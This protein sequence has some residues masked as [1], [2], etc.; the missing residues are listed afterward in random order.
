[1]R[2]RACAALPW[3]THPAAAG[4]RGQGTQVAP[5]TL[6]RLCPGRKRATGTLRGTT[7]A[8]GGVSLLGGARAL[9]PGR[10][11]FPAR[12]SRTT[13]SLGPHARARVERH[14]ARRGAARCLGGTARDAR[15]LRHPSHHFSAG[16]A[17][18][19]KRAGGGENSPCPCG[20]ARTVKGSSGSWARCAASS[21][22]AATSCC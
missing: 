17:R 5:G 16:R 14:L 4:P 19:R 12:T 15:P 13:R 20:L 10:G 21:E 7:A 6:V 3:C 1:M 22:N 9:A 8:A 2:P 18:R 11:V